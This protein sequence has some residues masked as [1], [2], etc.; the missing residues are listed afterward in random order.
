MTARMSGL[1]AVVTGGGSG[2]GAAT[3][4]AFHT[5]GARVAVLDRD[6]GAA[7]H[8]AA[9]LDGAISVAV[10]IADSAAVDAAIAEVVTAMG[11]VDVLA[12][13]AG[14]DDPEAKART[15]AR[16]ATGK[17]LDVTATM[18][19]AAWRRIMS[20]N[21]DGSFYM[22]RAALR[23]M[24]AQGSGSIINMSSL[25]GVVGAAGQPHY[26]AAKAA[27]VG[28]TQ[29]VAREVAP[30][31]VRVN[32]IAPGPVITPMLLRTVGTPA[33]SAGP[34]DAPPAVPAIR[35]VP[36]QRFADAS[37]VASVAVFLA[38]GDSSYVTGDVIHI[39]G[40]LRAV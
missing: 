37:E 35:S 17:P 6:A 10:D 26:S 27:I 36:M 32:A 7:A 3:C 21:L 14:I 22:L 12:N 30:L 29:S 5:E 9:D 39:D 16:R 13:F 20:V 25:A 23:V 1:V 15:A 2:I 18:T 19:D 28:L 33:A 4:L 11:T 31:G 8:T 24:T 38:C 40:A 34:T